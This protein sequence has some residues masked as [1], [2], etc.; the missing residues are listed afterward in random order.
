[1]QLKKQIDITLIRLSIMIEDEFN[2][3]L[4]LK[5]IHNILKDN[6]IS[7]KRIR[8][9]YYPEKKLSTEKEDLKK[10]Y[11]NINK[12]SIDKIISIDETALYLNMHL[13]YGRSKKG[14]RAII[15]TTSYPFIKFNC[16]CA[17]TNKKIIGLKIYKDLK[18]GINANDFIKFIDDNIKN[19]YK[20]Y[21]ILLDNAPFHRSQN[22]KN[23][24]LNIDNKYLFTIPYHPETNP[25]EMFFSQL[26]HYI[27]E[28]SPKNIN[29]LE[30]VVKKILKTK[31]KKKHL[32]NYFNYSF[33]KF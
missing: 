6:D 27:K 30:E 1:M 18:G 32:K 5:T 31:I 8:K 4:D 14:K 3:I 26:K 7:R 9:K 29:D 20:N 25:I 10:F 21:T 12:L 11:E 2:I 33:K 28:E 15:K 19:K 13:A 24:I 17:I 22:I 16:L 23:K